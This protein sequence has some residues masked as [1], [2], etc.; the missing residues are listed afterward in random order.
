[1]VYEQEKGYLLTFDLKINDLTKYYS[2]TSPKNA[3]KVIKK[4]LE[5]EGF[6]SKKDSDYLIY[7]KS[8][9]EIVQILSSFSEK[10]KWFPL[11]VEKISVTEIK[12]VWD[13]SKQV[14]S[15]YI[16]KDF[17]QAKD[18]QFE[19]MQKERK[20]SISNKIDKARIQSEKSKSSTKINT[21]SRER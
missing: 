14:K 15:E 9:L 19:S 12:D 7:N 3:Y 1:M 11:C 18:K 8:N 13:I 2:N 17:K 5:S 10:E 16:D 6:E 20:G 4:Y 21:K